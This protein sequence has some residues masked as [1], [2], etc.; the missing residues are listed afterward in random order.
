SDRMRTL[1]W[2]LK[3]RPWWKAHSFY[4][5]TGRALPDALRQNALLIAKAALTAG[6]PDPYPGRIL[7]FRPTERPKGPL[8]D[9]YLGWRSISRNVELH[10]VPGDHKHLLLPPNV[11]SIGQQLRACLGS[12]PSRVRETVSA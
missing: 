4:V 9:T 8:D 6:P 11:S 1:R 12:G 3:T 5:R 2:H 7:L 10:E